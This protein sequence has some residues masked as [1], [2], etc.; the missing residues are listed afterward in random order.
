[1]RHLVPEGVNP[2]LRC[3]ILH[4][5]SALC[6]IGR[7]K[8]IT[9]RLFTYGTSGQPQRIYAKLPHAVYLLV[10]PSLAADLSP[11]RNSFYFFT[12]GG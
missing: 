12:K 8:E 7:V 9:L 5:S 3:K 4:F 10:A 2:A 1:M 6:L 11:K